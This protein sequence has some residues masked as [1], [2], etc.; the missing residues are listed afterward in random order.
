MLLCN[1]KESGVNVR[2]F[3]PRAALSYECVG[4]NLEGMSL[5]QNLLKTR[6]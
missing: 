6:V 5:P 1:S 4:K 2:D 3:Q